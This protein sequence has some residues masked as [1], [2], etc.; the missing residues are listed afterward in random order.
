MSVRSIGGVSLSASQ[1]AVARV[2]WPRGFCSDTG[3]GRTGYVAAPPRSVGERLWR[4]AWRGRCS[5][6][7]FADEHLPEAAH[8]HECQ[9]D[10]LDGV[11]PNHEPDDR[12]D[13]ADEE[14][15]EQD[16]SK[17]HAAD[18]TGVLPL[19]RKQMQMSG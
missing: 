18:P 10:H 5:A 16:G 19:A 14:G 12:D 13:G 1:L 2:P 9:P 15:N 7:G 17:R 8:D 11:L 3:P 6:A 4:V